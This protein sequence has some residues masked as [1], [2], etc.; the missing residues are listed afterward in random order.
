[1]S[2]IY[3]KIS[4]KSF[5]GKAISVETH[6]LADDIMS[7]TDIATIFE[8]L[9]EKSRRDERHI[10]NSS[11]T[12]SSSETRKEETEKNIHNKQ[13]PLNEIN[14]WSTS[15]WLGAW[16]AAATKVDNINLKHKK[17]FLFR[18]RICEPLKLHANGS[19]TK[20]VKYTWKIGGYIK[21]N[22]KD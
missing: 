4:R 13:K 21:T 15:E 17:H 8:L 22:I 10:N 6:F 19:E 11:K 12:L 16:S 2:P 7:S 14:F 9:C 18:S 3:R 1:M 20:K 5:F